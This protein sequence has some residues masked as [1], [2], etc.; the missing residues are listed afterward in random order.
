VKKQV[1]SPRETLCQSGLERFVMNVEVFADADS[2]AWDLVQTFLAAEF[3]QAERH[4][5][6]LG[7]VALLETTTVGNHA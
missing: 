4:V 1:L 7:K 2:V 5:R 6:R 3:S